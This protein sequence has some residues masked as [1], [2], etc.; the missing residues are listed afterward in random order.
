MTGSITYKHNTDFIFP[1]SQAP[2]DV[3]LPEISESS[4]LVWYKPSWCG[5]KATSEADLEP[6][7]KIIQIFKFVDYFFCL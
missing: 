3:Y 1:Q 6:C 2:I 5:S 4:T 7:K